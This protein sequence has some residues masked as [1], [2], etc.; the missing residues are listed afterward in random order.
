MFQL[1]QKV[2]KVI[3]SIDDYYGEYIAILILLG[4]NLF[5]ALVIF[6]GCE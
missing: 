5:A 4:T 2:K 3:Y 1:L 6:M